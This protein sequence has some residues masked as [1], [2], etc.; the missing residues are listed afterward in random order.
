VISGLRRLPSHRGLALHAANTVF[1]DAL[2]PPGTLVASPTF[3]NAV[4]DPLV[5]LPGQLEWLLWSFTGRR[6]SDTFGKHTSID[7]ILFVPGVRFKVLACEDRDGVTQL[8]AREVVEANPVDELTAHD[9]SILDRLRQVSVARA[10]VSRDDR[11]PVLSAE[12]HEWILDEIGV[13]VSRA[14]APRPAGLTLR[15]DRR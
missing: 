1:A 5:G 2:T 14:T 11:R 10:A 9:R 15:G 3:L 6:V 8:F 7:R 4:G 13:V 12:E